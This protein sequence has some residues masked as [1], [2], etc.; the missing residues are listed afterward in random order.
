MVVTTIIGVLASVAA[1]QVFGYMRASTTVQVVHTA[2]HVENAIWSY[3]Q[4]S[5]KPTATVKAEIDGRTITPDLSGSNEFTDLIPVFQPAP[6][7]D[8]DYVV[9]AEVAASGPLAGEIVYCIL[10][11][12]RTS[13]A[14]PDGHVLYSSAN[15]TAPGRDGRI[16]RTPY[17]S[18]DADLG[19]VQA[20]G[21][22][23]ADGTASASC[24]LC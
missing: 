19:N 13:A 15:T 21:Y 7:G 9:S 8:F 12:G 10:A 1:P 6:N 3:L 14:V 17:V 16:N 4:S 23:A 22:C 5:L 24:T 11:T 18:G 20:G 2:S